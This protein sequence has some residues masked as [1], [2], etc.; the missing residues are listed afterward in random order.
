MECRVLQEINF[1]VHSLLHKLCHRA[2]VVGGG[3]C[4]GVL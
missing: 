3:G 1:K 2:L 4:D